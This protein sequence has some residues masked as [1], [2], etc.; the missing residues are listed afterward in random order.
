MS[1]FQNAENS[2]IIYAWSDLSTS[3]DIDF[4]QQPGKP[5]CGRTTWKTMI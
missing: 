2:D 4:N 5:G 3:R 1:L